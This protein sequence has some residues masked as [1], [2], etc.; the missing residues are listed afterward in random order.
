MTEMRKKALE[1]TIG[2]KRSAETR[3]KISEGH[4]G[5][6]AKPIKCI[7][8]KEIFNSI[9]EAANKYGVCHESIRVAVHNGKAS[10]GLHFAL[11]KVGGK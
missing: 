7:E 11:I 4:K 10:C 2:V 9:Q 8:T 6:G 5:L 1:S 3:K